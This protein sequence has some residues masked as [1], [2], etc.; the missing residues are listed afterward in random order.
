[1]LNGSQSR[2]AKDYQ[3]ARAGVAAV[4]LAKGIAVQVKAPFAAGLCRGRR[5]YPLTSEAGF[6]FPSSDRRVFS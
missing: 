4:I 1:V 6:S 2:R 5:P 3:V